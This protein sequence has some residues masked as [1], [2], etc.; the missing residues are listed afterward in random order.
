MLA[1][2]IVISAARRR[3][4][5]YSEVIAVAFGTLEPKPRPVSN[6]QNASW[7]TFPERAVHV[8]AIPISVQAAIRIGRRPTRSP[9]PATNA[10]PS[11]YPTRAAVVGSVKPPRVRCH[12]PAS[13]FTV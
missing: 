1:Y 9:N 7:L 2:I 13:Q 5:T 8:D 11:A 4:G 3:L 12:S 10:A 6:R